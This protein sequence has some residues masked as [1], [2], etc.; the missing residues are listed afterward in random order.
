MTRIKFTV[1]YDGSDYCGWQKQNHEDRPSVCQT[2]Q[3]GLEKIFQHKIV[4]MASGRTDAGVHALNQVCHFDTTRDFSKTKEWDLGWALRRY[5]PMSIIVK[6]AW[7]APKDFHATASAEKKTYKYL[8]YNA[9][10]PS[11][12]PCKYMGW[13]RRPLNLDHLNSSSEFLL[14]YQDFKSFQSVGTSVAHTNRTIY[15][16]SWRWKK[17]NIAEFSI[18]GSGFL[19]Q[20]VRN[21]VGTQ[22]LLEQKNL[23]ST[24]FKRIIELADRKYAGPPA[25]PQG[26]YL[27]QVYYP[28]DLD[29]KCREL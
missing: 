3:T 29:N 11:P 7:V 15:K 5:V 14:G 12:I 1:S 28:L 20:M 21:I 6:K 22:L 18:T 17:P 13:V 4:L 26:L 8:I 25:E 2:L 10:Q 19:K 24:D 9:K 27:L 23:P 16:A